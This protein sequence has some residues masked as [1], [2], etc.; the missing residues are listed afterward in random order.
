MM[1]L[2]FKPSTWSI[3]LK[4][5]L[6]VA[7]L[8]IVIGSIVTERV[9]EKLS[10]IQD[11][12]LRELSGAYFDGLS[13]LVVPHILRDDIWE[14]FD[15]IERSKAQYKGIDIVSTIVVDGDDNIIAA[16]DPSIFPTGEGISK[17]YLEISI[18]TNMLQIMSD[19][20]E[21]RVFQN[22]VF[23]GKMIGKLIVTL[24]VSRQL[25]ERDQVT[26]ALIGSN[27]AVTFFLAIFGYF[28]VRRMTKPMH[29][30]TEHL[31]KNEE[32]G[33]KEITASEFPSTSSEAEKLFASYNSMVRAMVERD[34]LADSLH[35]EEKL[36]G[37]GRLAAV[38]AHEI[39]NPLG[40]L[41]TA[42]ETLKR[43]GDDPEVNKKTIGLL[44][45][46]LKSIGDVVQTSLLAYRQR[47]ERRNLRGRDLAD[48]RRLLRPQ[49]S[50][51]SQTFD[52]NMEWSGAIPLDGTN[53]RQI[54]LNLLLNASKAAGQ[55]GKIGFHSS[56]T[57]SDLTITV[58]NDGKGIPQRLLDCLNSN[59]SKKNIPLEDGVGIGLWVICRMVDE[60]QGKILA[61]S[62]DVWTSVSVVIPFKLEAKKH[63]V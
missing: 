56:I 41:L 25:S 51:R 32:G 57:T 61:S 38:M 44:E 1:P 7:T 54:G 63:A 40:G 14:V 48:L 60:M 6:V 9:L 62:T 19:H 29:V 31:N 47:S 21:V 52:W 33:F 37:L 16:S 12:G 23:Q 59:E 35:E 4:I 2:I 28:V 58:A 3:S 46:G 18:P 5:P 50:R 45:R 8:M 42:L 17:E 10:E 20:P 15:A 13:S 43:H 27:A 36:A 55:G 30:L 24:D 26:F 34:Q 11:Q 53:V 39:N 22:V 49:T